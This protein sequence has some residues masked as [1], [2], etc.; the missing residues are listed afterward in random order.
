M[1]L[2]SSCFKKGTAASDSIHLL[3]LTQTHL[4]ITFNIDVN[5]LKVEQGPGGE[6]SV[7]KALALLRYENLSLILSTH[8]RMLGVLLVCACNPPNTAAM[9]I[10]DPGAC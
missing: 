3:K 10:P 6:G 1:N 7:G 5:N 9:A 2:L 4:D 8:I